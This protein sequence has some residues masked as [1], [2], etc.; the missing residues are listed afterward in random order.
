MSLAR[1]TFRHSSACSRAGADINKRDDHGQTA[2][3]LAALEGHERAVAF[4][5]GR[6]AE[7]NHTAKSLPECAHACRHPR[8]IAGSH[9]LLV[10]AGRRSR[11]SR[12][13]GAPGF[14][15][16]TARELAAVRGYADV[17]EL[18]NR[19]QRERAR[20]ASFRAVGIA[21][22]SRL[23][24]RSLSLPP[25][26]RGTG[27]RQAITSY[28]DAHQDE[29]L[30]LLERVVNIN[31]GTQNFDGV[32]AGRRALPR[33]A[34]R[35]RLQ[36]ALGRRRAVGSAPA[37]W[38]PTHPGPA[39]AAADRPSR[40]RVRARQPVPEVRAARR[41]H[42]RGP[43]I[44]DMKGGDVIIIQALKALKAAGALDRMNMIV[45]MTGDEEDAGDPLA[46]RARRWSR[47]PR[48]R[49]PRSASRT[50]TAI[51]RTR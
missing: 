51:P 9:S 8:A 3:M 16:K 35:A 50:A 20:H 23:C 49:P 33:R 1:V 26:S 32:R 42:A 28:V 11:R 31:S 25:S 45:V 14:E 40:H 44:I 18:I 6:G 46:R 13:S 37:I 10:N 47:P 43:G 19:A 30:A 2:L 38:S 24:V 48:A 29:A 12:R 21:A 17:V 5:A 34:R 36:D 15:G 27:Q 39:E 7:L 4:L 22:A 41:R